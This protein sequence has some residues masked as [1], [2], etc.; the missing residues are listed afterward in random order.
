MNHNGDDGAC[1]NST[2]SS[3]ILQ[4]TAGT[5]LLEAPPSVV[6][7]KT[8]D[9]FLQ[10]SVVWEQ[11]VQCSMPRG[12]GG[13]T[14]TTTG[15]SSTAAWNLPRA[16]WTRRRSE[17]T[18]QSSGSGTSDGRSGHF[19][20]DEAPLT[21]WVSV[22]QTVDR[23]VQWIGLASSSSY[24]EDLGLEP[25]DLDH[26][27]LCFMGVQCPSNGQIQGMA[28]IYNKVGTLSNVLFVQGTVPPQQ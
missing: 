12:A 4:K 2:P 11:L 22:D 27:T 16:K 21:C 20:N 3:F 26:G 24:S 14:T 25:Q 6:T 5:N 8:K 18:A 19:N 15:Q 1:W 10:T 23:F 13:T 9:P 17:E 28:R 7:F